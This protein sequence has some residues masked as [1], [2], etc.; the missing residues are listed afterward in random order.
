LKENVSVIRHLITIKEKFK[1][2][3]VSTK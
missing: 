2:Y 1:P 3:K